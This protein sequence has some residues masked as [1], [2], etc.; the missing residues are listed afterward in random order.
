MCFW[1]QLFNFLL[2][3][4]FATTVLIKLVISKQNLVD[5]IIA[6]TKSQL[7]LF[8]SNLYKQVD[9]FVF[10]CSIEE[11]LESVYWQDTDLL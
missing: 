5:L 3:K 11:S 9:D 2:I 8:N 4:R 6:A 10:M 1:K 7:F